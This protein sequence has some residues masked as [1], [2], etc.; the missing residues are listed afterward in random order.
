MFD[1]A[2]LAQLIGGENT[3]I[4]M[5]DLR[6]HSVV[7]GYPND[8]TIKA[9]WKVRRVPKRYLTVMADEIGRQVLQP[10]TEA[11]LDQICDELCTTSSVRHIPSL[12]HTRANDRLGF[13]HLNPQFGIRF[14]T[15]D[16]TRLPSACMSCHRR[17]GAKS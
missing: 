6:E 12:V 10:R 14:G 3:L 16:K 5:D 8:K 17:C 9:F 13:A 2:E 4:D 11:K 7:S 1:Q 15:S